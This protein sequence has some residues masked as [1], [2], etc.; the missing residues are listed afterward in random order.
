MLGIFV[1]NLIHIKEKLRKGS[2]GSRRYL[3][4]NKWRTKKE[5][6]DGMDKNFHKIKK[7]NYWVHPK[8]ENPK[9]R[10]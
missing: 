3:R 5:I 6:F 4:I 9:I 2:V 10:S 7:K 8:W 1:G